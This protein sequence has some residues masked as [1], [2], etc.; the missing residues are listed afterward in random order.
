MDALTRVLEL[1]RMQGVPDLR[2]QLGG[3]YRI[4]HDDMPSGT[5]PFH[6]VLSGEVDMEL[7]GRAPM[8]LHAGDLVVLPHGCSH[9]LRDVHGKEAAGP[10]LL[11][12]AGAI[13]VQHN[14][15][16]AELDVLCGRVLLAPEISRWLFATL[17][18]AIHVNLAASHGMG[19]LAGIVAILRDEVA[20]QPPGAVS[21][22]TALTQTL[23]VFALRDHLVDTTLTPSFLALLGDP[24]LSRAVTAMLRE[25]E[26][27]WSVAALAE[28]AAMSRATFARHFEARAR[29]SPHET[30]TLLRMQLA[31]DLLRRTD[32]T[33]GAVADR[34]GYRSESA[35]GK[36]FTRV[37][38]QTPARYRRQA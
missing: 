2:C 31:G 14:G 25:P 34:V 35:F 37:M 19:A 21:V 3:A 28:L 36:A 9:R 32:L 26:R 15:L 23:F 27:E 12:T 16:P 8:R 20:R 22:I 33:A 30:L 5:A 6:L 1:A 18:D 29:M 11:E 24:R 7:P 17:P 13:P 38:G 10:L 4:D